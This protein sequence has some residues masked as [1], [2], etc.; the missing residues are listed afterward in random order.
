[1][2]IAKLRLLPGIVKKTLA[3]LSG[4]HRPGAAA[5]RVPARQSAPP[6]P[7]P[8]S[9]AS[10]TSLAA[11]LITGYADDNAELFERA[12]RLG[13]KAERLE[14]EGTP[15]DTARNRADR[16]KAEIEAGFAR[17][18]ASFAS[19]DGPGEGSDPRGERLRA[20]D[21]EVSRLYPGFGTPGGHD[22]GPA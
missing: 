21:R 1:M 5:E 12:G 7:G 4:R 10:L 9:F 20:F 15:S 8:R 19:A 11:E 16:A 22:G 6:N 13:A 17:L 3:K 14:G 18:R 2:G